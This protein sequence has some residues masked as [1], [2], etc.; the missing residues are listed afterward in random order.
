MA[1]INHDRIFESGVTVGV[2]VVSGKGA[3]VEGDRAGT[4]DADA[5]GLIGSK[6]S[7]VDNDFSGGVN[8]RGAE[9]AGRVGAAF[10]GNPAAASVCADRG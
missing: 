2:G 7:V 3:V 10:D 1:L 8:G 5:F 9:T 4:L 6:L